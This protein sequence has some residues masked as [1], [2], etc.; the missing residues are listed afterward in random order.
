MSRRKSGKKMKSVSQFKDVWGS[1]EIDKLRG[2]YYLDGEHNVVPWR[3]HFD[4]YKDYLEWWGSNT[5]R[6]L[7]HDRVGPATVSTVFLGLDHNILGVGK[8]VV[9]ETMVFGGV[10]AG[11][12]NRYCTYQDAKEGHE[13]MIKRQPSGLTRK[14]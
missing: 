8:P 13:E 14:Q 11:A 12:M 7:F 2:W 6:Q 10:H 9:F 4:T 1:D 3:D 5:K